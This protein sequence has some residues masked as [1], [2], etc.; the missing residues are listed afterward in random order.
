MVVSK[1]VLEHGEGYSHVGCHVVLVKIAQNSLERAV[2]H[3]SVLYS[4]TGV[5][6]TSSCWHVSIPL[7]S[8][9]RDVRFAS[10]ASV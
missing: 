2:D 7:S 5:G 1:C 10:L 6:V 9:S 8:H 3:V 4:W